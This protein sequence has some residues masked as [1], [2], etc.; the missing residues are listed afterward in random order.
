MTADRL[1][2]SLLKNCSVL[3]VVLEWKCSPGSAET[4]LLLHDPGYVW[5]SGHVITGD[6]KKPVGG[7]YVFNFFAKAQVCLH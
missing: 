3:H 5:N 1:I 6:L 4:H 7:Q 2:T